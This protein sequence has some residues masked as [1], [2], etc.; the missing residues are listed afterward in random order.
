MAHVT[1]FEL[2]K[3]RKTGEMKRKSIKS[4]NAV[5]CRSQNVPFSSNGDFFGVKL[6]LIVLAAQKY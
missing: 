3:G 2:E 4:V 5:F 6:T 1:Y